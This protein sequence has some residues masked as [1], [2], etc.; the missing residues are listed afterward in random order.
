M[1]SSTLCSCFSAP[2]NFNLRS[3]SLVPSGDVESPFFFIPPPS[4]VAADR[5]RR[6]LQPFAVNEHAS[7]LRPDDQTVA[8]FAREKVKLPAR[9]V[10][11]GLDVCDLRART[12][13]NVATIGFAPAGFDVGVTRFQRQHIDEDVF[14]V[15][16]NRIAL[17]EL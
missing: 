2:N 14:G 16:V 15:D 12:D 8:G 9:A 5:S 13:N 3:L 1:C 4:G 11:G 7:R 17:L 10:G 6:R